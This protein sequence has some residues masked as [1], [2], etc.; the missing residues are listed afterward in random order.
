MLKIYGCPMHYGVGAKGL[1]HSLEYIQTHYKDIDMVVLPEITEAED[2]LENLKNLN[3]IVS[4]CDEIAKY[5][6]HEILEKGDIPLFI[7]GDHSA[8]IGSMSAPSAYYADEVG[9][10]WVDAHP[11]IN[12]DAT[13]V[14][15]NIHGMPVASLLG[16]GEASLTHFL[17]DEKKV[18]PEN[19]VYI[20]LRDI[21]PPE[22]RFIEEMNIQH[23]TYD[24][25]KARGL[26]AC[27]DESIAYL[28]HLK[29]V[30][31]SFDIDSVNPKYLPGVSTPVQDGFTISEAFHVVERYSEALPICSY[32]IVEF[33]AGTDQD[34]KTADFLIDL[35]H[36]IEKKVSEK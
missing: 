15:G 12:T 23:Y 14:S 20:G 21:D 10:I 18:K 13:T 1:I 24:D 26:D 32:D 30:H 3:S 8:T 34:N 17:T 19:I 16:M 33:N 6:Y 27:L 36:F 11:D 35:I 4:T 22:A 9:L 31:L 29:H 28:S 5:G 2:G 25:V 7:G